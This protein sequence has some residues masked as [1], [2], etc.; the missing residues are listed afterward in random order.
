M[1]K[2]LAFFLV[3]V[4]L[5]AQD[6]DGSVAIANAIR[7]LEHGDATLPNFTGCVADLVAVQVA[8]KDAVKA[9]TK[10]TKEIGNTSRRIANEAADATKASRPVL[11]YSRYGYGYYGRSYYSRPYYSRPR[12]APTYHS[13]PERPVA[14][15]R[16]AT[17][18][19]PSSQRGK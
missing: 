16:H 14:P 5:W 4:P 2:F 12:P 8:S 7:P 19:C 1:G 15:E 6:Q 18:Q 10:V 13:A 11:V 3:F 17:P 9:C